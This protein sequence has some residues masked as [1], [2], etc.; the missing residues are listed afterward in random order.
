MAQTNQ[1]NEH[2]IFPLIPICHSQMGNNATP[3]LNNPNPKICWQFTRKTIH[4]ITN[5]FQSN[6]VKVTIY[7]EA[8]LYIKKRLKDVSTRHPA[9]YENTVKLYVWLRLLSI[10][11]LVHVSQV[12]MAKMLFAGHEER[13][14]ASVLEL[15]KLGL[16]KTVM[17]RNN[18]SGRSYYKYYAYPIEIDIINRN[19]TTIFNYSNASIK[20]LEN[21]KRCYI[22]EAWLEQNQIGNSENACSFLTRMMGWY[23]ELEGLKNND[24]VAYVS[25][26]NGRCY[27]PFHQSKKEDRHLIRWDGE[28]IHE[29]W[30]ANASFYM[31]LCYMLRQKA[32]SGNIKNEAVILKE[33]ERL[34]NLCLKEGFYE[35]V[36]V[37]YERKSGDRLS[38]NAIK[39]LCQ[40]YRTRWREYFFTKNGTYKNTVWINELKYI[41]Q[42]FEENF[43]N[44]R[45]IILDSEVITVD[46]P[47]YLEWMPKRKGGY[48]F[49][50]SKTR[51]ISTLDRTV[52]PYE[53]DLI[54]NGVCKR[55]YEEYNVQSISLHDG[56]YVKNSDFNVYTVIPDILR[57][58]LDVPLPQMPQFSIG[59]LKTIPPPPQ[60]F[61][62]VSQQ[63]M[64]QFNLNTPNLTQFSVT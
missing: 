49:D 21:C 6:E 53:L 12:E 20:S 58:I 54:T 15:E 9:S 16:V 46:N 18:L 22:D 64:Y 38:R 39:I 7:R 23:D 4:C 1:E 41:D 59:E 35:D 29:V 11:R 51:K 52:T 57:E 33:T 3:I 34:L 56:I 31:A 36:E 28:P 17:E 24:K 40:K 2:P 19:D 13:L 8:K 48:Y 47:H 62:P 42:Y 14:T 37:Y 61:I 5:P 27:H 60:P 43:P 50:G 45:N 55:L 10:L 44:I 63:S 30:D 25:K 32:Q 26:L